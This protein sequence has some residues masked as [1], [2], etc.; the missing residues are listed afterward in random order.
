MNDLIIFTHI[1]KT[2]GVSFLKGVVEENISSEKIYEYRRLPQFV[3]S[4]SQD[5]DFIHGHVPYGGHLFT[6]RPV[7]YVTFL[8]DP[9]DRAIS[10]YYFVQ[11]GGER[12]ETRHPLCNYAE[13]VSLKEFYKNPI[14]HNHQ[15][16][17]LAGYVSDK[18]YQYIHSSFIKK[19]I[20]QRATSN[21][22]AKYKCFGLLEYRD[23]SIKWFKE[24]MGWT[25]S[26]EVPHQKKTFKRKKIDDVD[27][28]TLETIR[29]SHDLDI[30]LYQH[31][32]KLFPYKD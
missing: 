19:R 7:Q 24:R 27:E 17:F 8:R 32:L 28:E 10:F 2:S 11:Q 14:F 20:L 30:Q 31:A 12:P 18:F 21:L 9:I 25:D 22:E 6:Q 4:A 29:Q 26:V 1:P 13:S 5:I 15:T 3:A 16:R 23:E